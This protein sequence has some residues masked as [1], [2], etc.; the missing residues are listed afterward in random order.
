MAWRL[1]EAFYM[2]GDEHLHQ[3]R[4]HASICTLQIKGF[5]GRAFE[6][7]SGFLNIFGLSW[8]FFWNLSD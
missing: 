1:S 2:I 3:L 7:C 6:T 8:K 5:T 4:H